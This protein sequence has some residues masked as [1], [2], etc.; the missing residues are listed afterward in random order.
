[1]NNVNSVGVAAGHQEEV[2]D[3]NKRWDQ[4]KEQLKNRLGNNN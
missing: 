1:M 4:V 3:L 2:R